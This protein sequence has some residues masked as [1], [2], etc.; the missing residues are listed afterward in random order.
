[1]T[2]I[3]AGLELAPG[4]P[5]LRPMLEE[6]L[7]AARDAAAQA[8][9]AALAVTPAAANLTTYREADLRVRDAAHSAQNGSPIE[10]VRAYW[11]A[12]AL[13]IRAE[14]EAQLQS[15]PSAA[16]AA[17]AAPA[18]ATRP[19]EEPRGAVGQPSS[20]AVP[21]APRSAAAVAGASGPAASRAMPPSDEPAIRTVLRSYA[22]A[23][24]GLDA[25]AVQ[26]V[27]PS[28][29]EP[30]LRRAFSGLRSQQVEIQ[31][32][33]LAI[34]GETASV[35]CMLVTLAIGQVGA[36]TPRRDARR[37]VF[38]LARRDGT[39]VIVDRR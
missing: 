37:V 3:A 38:T 39:W 2:T 9:S 26:R 24:S 12:E 34:N 17:P 30:A 6:A 10:A 19:P 8:R 23:Y 28:V 13:F 22:A 14:S 1:L 29:N 4:D 25:G 36:A 33:Q 27:F 21:P 11:L 20:A 16:P 5:V 7:D 31:D 35:S 18:A 15:P 32:E